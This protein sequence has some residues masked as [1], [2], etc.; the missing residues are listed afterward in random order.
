MVRS[1]H[2]S[3]GHNAEMFLSG[4][5]TLVLRGTRKGQKPGVEVVFAVKVFESGPGQLPG[6]AFMVDQDVE[7]HYKETARSIGPS[8]RR[9][10]NL[11]EAKDA[12][13]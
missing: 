10:K 9:E 7:D 2:T 13:R 5:N 4:S 11:A 8:I 12:G 6:V 1:D 3:I